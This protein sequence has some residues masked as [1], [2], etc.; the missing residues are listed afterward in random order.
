MGTCAS[1]YQPSEELKQSMID[2]A[3]SSKYTFLHQDPAVLAENF[4]DPI[5]DKNPDDGDKVLACFGGQYSSDTS[6]QNMPY[7][8]MDSSYSQR[9]CSKGIIEKDANG[10]TISITPDSK[11]CDHWPQEELKNIPVMKEHVKEALKFLSKDVSLLFISTLL[12]VARSTGSHLNTF[13][14]QCRHF[15][16]KM[17][18]SLCMSKETLI[19]RPTPITWTM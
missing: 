19:G 11:I 15:F 2:G 14:N 3:L 17:D 1:R 12:F 18:F 10:A 9:W 4:Y 7:R 8:G 6:L 13:M 5:Q 16:R